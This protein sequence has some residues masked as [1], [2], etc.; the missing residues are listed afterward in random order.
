MG[1]IIKEIDQRTGVKDGR[2][3]YTVY[4]DTSFGS[5]Y[6]R[7]FAIDPLDAYTKATVYL[8][9]ES[10]IVRV[11]LICGTILLLSLLS[12]VTYSCTRD[13]DTAANFRTACLDHNKSIV[14]ENNGTSCR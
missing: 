7:I 11:F 2:G 3:E 13:R 5:S 10:K 6:V 4:Y 12:A 14:S 9:K 8:E 1:I